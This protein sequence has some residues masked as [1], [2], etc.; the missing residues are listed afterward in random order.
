MGVWGS[1]TPPSSGLQRPRRGGNESEEKEPRGFMSVVTWLDSKC[2]RPSVTDERKLDWRDSTL[3]V[4]GRGMGDAGE[5]GL[6]VVVLLLQL[7]WRREAAWPGKARQQ[8]EPSGRL[9]PRIMSSPRD[10]T[11]RGSSHSSLSL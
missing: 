1:T 6:L 7:R 5:G 11:S 8:M 2:D 3:G 9:A 4:S 10:F